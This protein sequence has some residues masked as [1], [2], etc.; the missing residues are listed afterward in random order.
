M[1]DIFRRSLVVIRKS[2]G[3]CVSGIWEDGEATSFNITASVQGTC[4]EV[5]QTM[6]EGSRASAT[7]TLRT[8]AKL[9]TSI[10][11]ETTPD[12]VVID[13]EK[14]VVLRVTPW[15][16]LQHTKHYEVVVTQVNYDED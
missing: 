6:P 2:K 12:I 13:D 14:F 5:L 15:Q 16:N 1:F 11:G 10:A 9:L 7:Y 8:D 3:R 4:A